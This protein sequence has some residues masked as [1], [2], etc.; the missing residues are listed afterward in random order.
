MGDLY[1]ALGDGTKA[2]QA[3]ADA[4]AIRE[5]L[6]L[7]E[8]ERADFQQDLAGSFQRMGDIAMA[9]EDVEKA[10]GY[11]V[12]AFELMQGLVEREPQRADFLRHLVVPMHRL[13]LLELPQSTSLLEQALGIL[14]HLKESGRLNPVDEPFKA[15]IA[16]L[17]A[18]H[19]DNGRDQT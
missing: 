19:K 17:V 5:R 10:H 8:P 2:Q 7:Q 15:Q 18:E 3:F 16:E 6:A 9:A 13:G 11:F 12:Q 1:T 14:S 4:L